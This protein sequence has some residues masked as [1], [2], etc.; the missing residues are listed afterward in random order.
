LTSRQFTI[1]FSYFET[2]KE[3]AQPEVTL[4]VRTTR[5]AD[6]LTLGILDQLPGGDPAGG[7]DG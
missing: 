7:R 5:A 4:G 1:G 3:D 6:C 2:G